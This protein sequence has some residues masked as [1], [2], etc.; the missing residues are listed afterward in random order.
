MFSGSTDEE[1]CCSPFPELQNT[2]LAGWIEQGNGIQ[3]PEE[4]VSYAISRRHMQILLVHEWVFYVDGNA[5]EVQKENWQIH[6]FSHYFKHRHRCSHAKRIHRVLWTGSIE[7]HA[8]AQD[9]SNLM[10]TCNER[11]DSHLSYLYYGPPEQHSA[12]VAYLLSLDYY[13]LIK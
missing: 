4:I 1:F 7:E 3:L 9:L 11:I 10:H 8:N 6:G 2:S 5:S 13:I 12:S